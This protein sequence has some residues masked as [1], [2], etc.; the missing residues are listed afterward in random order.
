MLNTLLRKRES[1]Q[2]RGA[3]PPGP[4]LRGAP[5]VSAHRD[6]D[7]AVVSP[8][9]PDDGPSATQAV[10]AIRRDLVRHLGREAPYPTE[11]RLTRRRLEVTVT[12]VLELIPELEPIESLPEGIGPA[13]ITE[14]PSLEAC[15]KAAQAELNRSW[16]ALMSGGRG[17]IPGPE[18]GAEDD[19]RRIWSAAGLQVSMLTCSACHGG[20]AIP[21]TG[22]RETGALACSNSACAGGTVGCPTCEGQGRLTMTKSPAGVSALM[23]G[24]PVQ[25]PQAGPEALTWVRCGRCDGSGRTTCDTCGGDGMVAC[26]TCGGHGRLTCPRCQGEGAFVQGVRAHVQLL[27]QNE[28]EVPAQLP[29]PLA[30]RLR[31]LP[32]LVRNALE[33]TEV[34]AP[35]TSESWRLAR[36]H[37]ALPL[38]TV[39]YVL[40]DAGGDPIRGQSALIGQTGELAWHRA[41]LEEWLQPDVANLEAALKPL[42]APARRVREALQWLRDIPLGQQCLAHAAE[43]RAAPPAPDWP[44]VTNGALSTGFG[45]RLLKLAQLVLRRMGPQSAKI[46]AQVIATGLIAGTVAVC[47]WQARRDLGVTDQDVRGWVQNNSLSW[48][49][50]AGGVLALT[51]QALVRGWQRVRLRLWLGRSPKRARVGM[52]AWGLSLLVAIT[53]LASYTLGMVVL[54][55]DQ[56]VGGTI[57]LTDPLAELAL[58]DEPDLL[59][60]LPPEEL[61]AQM[62]LDPRPPAPLPPRKP[63]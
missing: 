32:L 51:H 56:P 33:V 40:G 38:L 8:Q 55:P 46:P 5:P 29:E 62:A 30:E 53:P 15:R 6:H 61:D 14:Q 25:S 37:V 63:Q 31:D 35:R 10:E 58:P 41:T 3:S 16:T 52:F 36:W 49:L 13:Q 22:C 7:P 12:Q 59:D 24:P 17:E 1:K 2:D 42:N 19:Q 28:V 23:D 50:V 44:R 11:L 4:S 60:V 26:R 43:G 34:P 45:T 18:L 21:C 39:E 27:R 20:G 47:L 9:P 54:S 57:P 48:S